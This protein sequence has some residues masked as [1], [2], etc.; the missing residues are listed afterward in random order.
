MTT[1][2]TI[3]REWIDTA[4]YGLCLAMIMSVDQKS[5]QGVLWQCGQRRIFATVEQG[6]D[7]PSEVFRWSLTDEKACDAD[8]QGSSGWTCS[9]EFDDEFKALDAAQAFLETI[10]TDMSVDEIIARHPSDSY[11]GP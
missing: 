10:T 8:G 11:D 7:D 4:K 3:T 9:D 1:A 6:M 2:P 5:T